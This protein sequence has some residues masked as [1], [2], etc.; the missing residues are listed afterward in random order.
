MAAAHPAAGFAA[1]LL[2]TLLWAL[3]ISLAASGAYPP[4]SYHCAK[5]SLRV[6]LVPAASGNAHASVLA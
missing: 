6:H 2:L 5:R 3:P 1:R 4:L